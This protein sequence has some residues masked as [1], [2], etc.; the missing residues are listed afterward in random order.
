M[1]PSLNLGVSTYA[2]YAS[3][4]A[5]ANVMPQKYGAQSS[6]FASADVASMRFFHRMKKMQGLKKSRAG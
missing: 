6:Q 1:E 4:T 5:R 3:A 2:E